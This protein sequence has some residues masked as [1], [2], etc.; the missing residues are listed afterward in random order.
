MSKI[1]TTVVG[2]CRWCHRPFATFT[3]S[4]RYC[5]TECSREAWRAWR[6]QQAAREAGGQQ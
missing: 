4:R 6:Q 2:L 3:R 5:S 1:K